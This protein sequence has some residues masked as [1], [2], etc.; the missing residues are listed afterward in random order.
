[1][2]GYQALTANGTMKDLLSAVV[3]SE[4]TYARVRN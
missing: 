2:A 4:S 3:S 1:M